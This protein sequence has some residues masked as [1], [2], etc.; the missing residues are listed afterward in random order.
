MS[1]VI[2][3]EFS[4]NSVK[5]TESKGFFG[6]VK[7]MFNRA[8]SWAS[9]MILGAW[10]WASDKMG[11]YKSALWI[12][13]GILALTIFS[14]AAGISAIMFIISTTVYIAIFITIWNIISNSFVS[15]TA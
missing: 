15:T 13:V 7:N 1:E 10:N 9:E 4:D 12:V 11:E 6:S 3:A 2:N 8:T 14:P 5:K